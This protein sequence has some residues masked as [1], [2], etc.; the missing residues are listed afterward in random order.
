M[1][2]A[3][4]GLVIGGI[5]GISTA[6]TA[7][8]KAAARANLD[9]HFGDITLSV[10]EL[11]D[12]AR[13]IVSGGG[14]LFE[15]L[16][17]F[18][19]ASD[20]A[21]QLASSL[22]SSLAEIKKSDWKLSMGFDFDADDTQSYVDSIDSYLKNAQDYITNSGYE[23]KVAIGLVFGEDS[24]AGAELAEPAEL[25]SVPLSAA[26]AAGTVPSGC[27]G[28]YHGQRSGFTEAADGG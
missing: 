17:N 22:Q 20:D 25:L 2:V 15:Q 13:H 18:H 11:D 26:S 9:R 28:G 6:I 10:E 19:S 24:T 27:Y 23:M 1:A 3:A 7:A 5:A 14:N 8:E 16:D 21:K 12:A 4:A